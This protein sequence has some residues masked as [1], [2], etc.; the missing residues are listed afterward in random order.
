VYAPDGSGYKRLEVVDK[1]VFQNGAV[2]KFPTSTA[3]STGGGTGNEDIHEP[4]LPIDEISKPEK[5][6]PLKPLEPTN[7][8][9][10]KSEQKKENEGPEEKKK[11]EPKNENKNGIIKQKGR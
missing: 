1:A 5:E 9:F 2:I 6:K 10:E 8:S 11:P 3:L 7:E 4:T